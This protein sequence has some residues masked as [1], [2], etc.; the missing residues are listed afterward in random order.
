M[1]GVGI[2][3]F[4]TAQGIGDSVKKKWFNDYSGYVLMRCLDQNYGRL[5]GEGAGQERDSS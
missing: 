4:A 2:S 1:I 5:G 3:F